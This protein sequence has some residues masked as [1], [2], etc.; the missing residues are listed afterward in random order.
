MSYSPICA[1]YTVNSYIHKKAYIE[2]DYT[3]EMLFNSK[4]ISLQCRTPQFAPTAQEVGKLYRQCI[5]PQKH[6]RSWRKRHVH[7]MCTP[8]RRT[9]SQKRRT[10]TQK[11]PI[12]TSKRQKHKRSW[13]KR[14]FSFFVHTITKFRCTLEMPLSSIT[15]SRIG[16]NL[17]E[18]PYIHERKNHYINT[19]QT[20]KKNIYMQ[21]DV[22]TFKISVFSMCA[23]QF[24]KMRARTDLEITKKQY[25]NRDLD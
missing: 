5:H 19:Q 25:R 24:A 15:D 7:T 10:C 3:E 4:Y 2:S 1:S 23:P 17:T 14:Q 20:K 18:S 21:R 16:T 13:R 8:K 9:Y 12:C 6:K 11:R 22:C